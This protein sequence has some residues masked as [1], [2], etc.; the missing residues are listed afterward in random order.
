MSSMNGVSDGDCS[1]LLS[2][3]P[4]GDS[5]GYALQNNEIIGILTVF[6][7]YVGISTRLALC[8]VGWL[9]TQEFARSDRLP[10]VRLRGAL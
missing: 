1:T 5:Q 6:F 4:C 2:F 9:T 3:L 8:S 10:A 7:R